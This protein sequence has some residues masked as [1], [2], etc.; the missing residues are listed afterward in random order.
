MVAG[1]QLSQIY[2]P[3]AN[4]YNKKSIHVGFRPTSGNIMQFKSIDGRA[5]SGKTTH[6][7]QHATDLALS[8]EKVLILQPTCH[9]VDRTVKKLRDIPYL[10]VRAIHTGTQQAPSPQR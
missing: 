5:G 2:A 4:T 7:R 6:I 9:L 3:P 10:R 1:A 8:G